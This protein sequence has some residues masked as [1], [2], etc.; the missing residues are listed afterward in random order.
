[1]RR[2]AL[3]VGVNTCDHAIRSS[4]MREER[5][6]KHNYT[7]SNKVLRKNCDALR[8]LIDGQDDQLA[9]VLSPTLSMMEKMLKSRKPPKAN[10]S[11]KNV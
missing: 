4:N 7:P 6:I 10:R 3:F 9:Q 1:M 8:S 5:F 11:K 2:A